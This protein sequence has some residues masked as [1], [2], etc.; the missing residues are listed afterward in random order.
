MTKSE[1]ITGLEQAGHWTWIND[2]PLSKSTKNDPFPMKVNQKGEHVGDFAIAND[3]KHRETET[4]GMTWTEYVKGDRIIGWR[5]E[6]EVDT[7]TGE[8][9]RS[10]YFYIR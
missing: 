6:G 8:T 3:F 5:K 10:N 2:D 1:L 9:I 7:D 4:E